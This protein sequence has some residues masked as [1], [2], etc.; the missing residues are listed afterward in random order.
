MKET[1]MSE[2]VANA[3]DSGAAPKKRS[4]LPLIIAAVVVLAGAGGGAWY[5]LG[6]GGGEEGKAEEAEHVVAPAVYV[7]LDPP[8]VV[9]FESGGAVRFLQVA[10]QVMTR[11]PHT[12]EELGKHSPAIRN[13]LLLLLSNQEYAIISTREGKEKLQHDAL[14]AIRNV[15]KTNGGEGET[16]E[17]VL[18]TSFVMQ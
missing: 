1:A 4:K 16:V 8:F 12:V 5:F 18:F 11:D 17:S 10:I 7:S 2:A 9:N 3:A 14:E 15:V 13:D 6:R